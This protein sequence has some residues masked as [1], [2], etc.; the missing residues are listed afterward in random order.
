MQ[1]VRILICD[2]SVKP[3]KHVGLGFGLPMW[4]GFWRVM[5][6]KFLRSMDLLGLS[7]PV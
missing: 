4:C 1:E 6:D 7:Y 3:V 5:A 2:F